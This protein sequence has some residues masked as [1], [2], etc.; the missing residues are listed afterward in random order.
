MTIREEVAARMP[1]PDEASGLAVPDGVPVL[2]VLHTGVD[3]HGR[4]FE[5]TRFIMRA[6]VNGL[7]YRMPVEQ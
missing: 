3:E 7:D 5:V 2:D 4:A 6:D 1:T